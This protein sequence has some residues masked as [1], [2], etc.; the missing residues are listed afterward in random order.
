[1]PARTMDASLQS[2]QAFFADPF[3]VAGHLLGNGLKGAGPLAVALSALLLAAGFW[4]WRR[5]GRKGRTNVTARR[6]FSQT[7]GHLWSRMNAALPD[8]VILMSLPLTNFISVRKDG[9]LGRNQRKLEVL[10]ADFAVFRADGTVS[11]VVLLQERDET[12]TRRQIK[13]RA[14]L[15]ARAGIRTVNWTAKVLPSVDAITRQLQPATNFAAGAPLR[16][17]RAIRSGPAKGAD[18]V[19]AP[20]TRLV[21]SQASA[22]I[23]PA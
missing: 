1:M 3:G 16:A 6:G 22:E 11:S 15:L 8:H 9:G 4:L 5:R 18:S 20:D 10:S 13:L 7:E 19:V 21:A 17:R 12:M 2:L 23:R 14:K